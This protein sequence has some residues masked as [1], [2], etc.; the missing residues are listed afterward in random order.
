[1]GEST[2]PKISNSTKILNFF[3]ISCA[4]LKLSWLLLAEIIKAINREKGG[5]FFF[6]SN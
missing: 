5:K 1:M 2:G 6:F 3:F 4:A